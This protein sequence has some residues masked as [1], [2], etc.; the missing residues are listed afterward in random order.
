MAA[1]NQRHNLLREMAHIIDTR[2]L[3][4]LHVIKNSKN[5]KQTL[6]KFVE[7]FLTKQNC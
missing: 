4:H 1:G 7:N 3:F 5:L 6:E 2:S